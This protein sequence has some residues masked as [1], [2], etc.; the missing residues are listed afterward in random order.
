MQELII[1][2][3]INAGMAYGLTKSDL[4]H[5]F[6]EKLSSKQLQ[7]NTMGEIKNRW[8]WFLYH[9]FTFPFCFGFYSSIPAYLIAYR[10]FD[11][12]LIGHMF[13]GSIT[14]MLMFVI[15]NKLK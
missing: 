1:F 14:A 6:R 11:I 2:I 9:I 4:L 7:Y 13:I 5:E 3:L 10:A 15:I 8:I 12:M